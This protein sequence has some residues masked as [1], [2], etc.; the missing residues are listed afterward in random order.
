MFVVVVFEPIRGIQ[1]AIT[2][3]GR[4]P[5]RNKFLGIT[6]GSPSLF[7]IAT[8]VNIPC[9]LTFG[10]PYNHKIVV[11]RTL[12]FWGGETLITLRC[13]NAQ[14]QLLPYKRV[15]LNTAFGLGTCARLCSMFHERHNHFATLY[16]TLQAY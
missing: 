15:M 1:S 4:V 3:S 11:E 5:L 16:S 9:V 7:F 14:K 8:C 12:H 13:S 10:Y 6:L 2:F